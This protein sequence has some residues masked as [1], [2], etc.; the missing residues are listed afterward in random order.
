MT[1][2]I[3][4]TIPRHG[5]NIVDEVNDI[6]NTDTM[7]DTRHDA[8]DVPMIVARHVPMTV[9]SIETYR[10]ICSCDMVNTSRD[11]SAV[12]LYD[13][14]TNKVLAMSNRIDA[15]LTGGVTKT[16]DDAATAA[17]IRREAYNI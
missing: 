5:L 17:T 1:D 14:M 10:Y 16:D 8:R 6:D 9:T 13:T 12:V 15:F 4:E 3:L 11:M 2:N 7:T